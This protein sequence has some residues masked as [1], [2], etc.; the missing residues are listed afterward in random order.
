MSVRLAAGVVL[1]LLVAFVPAGGQAATPT[2]Q[3]TAFLTCSEANAMSVE[4]RRALALEVINA[5][6]RHF[7][8]QIPQDEQA[9]EHIGWLVRSGCTIAPEAYFTGVVARAVRVVGGGVE[10]PLQQPLDM[11]QVLFLTC[12]GTGALPREQLKQVGTFIGKEAAAHYGLT[13]GPDWTPDYVA[14][15]VHNGCKMYPDAYYLGM[16]GRAIRAV[17]GR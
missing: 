3:Q 13:P 5:A 17:A 6:A 10:P 2:L 12:S 8:T 9:G 7:Q 14:A 16:I 4:Q 15:L 11:E 1:A